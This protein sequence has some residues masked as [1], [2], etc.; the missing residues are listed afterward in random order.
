MGTMRFVLYI[1][2]IFA[3]LAFSSSTSLSAGKNIRICVKSDVEF[4]KCGDIKDASK[5][6]QCSFSCVKKTNTDD[7]IQAIAS[8]QADIITVDSGDIYKAS[9]FPFHL[10]PVMVEDY[11]TREESKTCYYAVAVVKKES[12]FKFSELKGRKTCH[13]GVNKA[14]GWIMP[15]GTLIN[16]RQ[17]KWEGPE[18]ESLERAMAKFFMACVPGSNE[19]NL[20]ILC[21]GSGQNKCARSENEP[22]YNYKGAFR[23]LH[24]GVGEVAFIKHT[25]VPAELADSYE[26]LCPDDTR[27]PVSDYKNCHL[28]KIP[29]HAVMASSKSENLKTEEIVACLTEAQEKLGS[30]LFSSPHGTDLIFK[31][32]TTKLKALPRMMESALYLGSDYLAAI[33]ALRRKENSPGNDKVNWC[34]VGNEEKKKCDVWSSVSGGTIDCTASDSTEECM[35]KILKREADAMTVDGGYLYTAG[36]CGLVPVLAEYYKE[37]CNKRWSSSDETASYFAVAIV[38]RNSDITWN[39][40]KGKKSC[41]TAVGRTVG[42]NVP[43]GLIYN[44]TQNCN[45]A[46]FFSQSCAPGADPSSSLCDLCIGSGLKKP[47][48]KCQPNTDEPYYGYT[49]AIRCPER[50]GRCGL[51]KG[52]TIFQ[53]TDGKNPASW[54][55]DLKSEDFKLLCLD[56]THANVKEF[57]KCHLARVSPHAVICSADKRDMVARIVLN[58]QSL[59]GR[60]GTESDLFQMFDSTFKDLLF[61]DTTQC[62]LEI[63]EGT[64]MKTY[65]GQQ[66]YDSVAGLSKCSSTSELLQVCNFHKCL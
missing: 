62:L 50:G 26:L 42:W 25:T 3:L 55:Q 5:D 37:D 10:K 63:P 32:C 60:N 19:P 56:G 35:T 17:L 24:E 21:K 64:T 18:Y 40:L 14:A 43:F 46:Q 51:C 36:A 65:L 45:F 44:Q 29:S 41:H 16:K 6:L 66:Y 30:T 38:K 39:N 33:Q 12:N 27:K 1:V 9:L 8:E 54:A 47:D 49:G 15:A 13:T 23:C 22:Y 2:L 48:S 59:F 31:D 61:K 52:S 11:G 7:C 57:P 58:Q 34:C 4:Q 20:C 53:N 28:S